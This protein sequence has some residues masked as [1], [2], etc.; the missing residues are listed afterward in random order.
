MNIKRSIR[1]AIENRKKDGVPVVENVPIR[2]QV[3]FNSKRIDF[4]TGYR[5]DAAKWD[6]AKQR[7]KNNATN[8][9]KQSASQINTDLAK[10]ETYINEIFQDFEAKETEPT[11]E[12]IKEAFADKLN[13]KSESKPKKQIKRREKKTDFFSVFDEFVKECGIQNN[14]TESTYEKFAAVRN[15]L[16]TFKKSVT[17]EFFDEFGLT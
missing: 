15:H 7:V 16:T 2:L 9:L 14:W 1:I 10:Y 8:K 17:F 6:S 12:Q 13:P 4:T 5:I 3:F 11:T